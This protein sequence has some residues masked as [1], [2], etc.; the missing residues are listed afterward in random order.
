MRNAS[1]I[2]STVSGE[3]SMCRA[4]CSCH[5]LLLS[6][7]RNGVELATSRSCMAIYSAQAGLK[8]SP[9]VIASSGDRQQ[10]KRSTSQ[11]ASLTSL[12]A[13]RTATASRKLSLMLAQTPAGGG[14]AGGTSSAR[15]NIARARVPR[16]RFS[17]CRRAA[18]ACQGKKNHTSTGQ[19]SKEND[20]MLTED[21]QDRKGKHA[22]TDPHTRTQ[23]TSNTTAVDSATALPPAGGS[24]PAA[25]CTPSP[26]QRPP[27]KS[28]LT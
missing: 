13:A 25:G 15:L 6:Y 1:A 8:L 14:C 20:M 26:P 4:G 16:R 23:G 19:S 11:R 2:L 18:G 27:S 12:P 5:Q 3:A 9:I 22:G 21:T 24:G 7:M 28:G 17:N 10:P